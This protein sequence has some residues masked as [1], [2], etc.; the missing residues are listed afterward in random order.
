M[1]PLTWGLTAFVCVALAA[2]VGSAL[3]VAARSGRR[4]AGLKAETPP[5]TLIRPICGLDE[6]ERETLAS[7]FGLEATDVE[8]LFCAKEAN[9]PAALF[10]E[11]LIAAHPA[12]CARLLIGNDLDT[13]NPKLNNVAKGWQAASHG[14]VILADSNLLLPPDYVAQV[15]S[16][17][18]DDTGLVCAPP[19]GARPGNFWAELEC[20]FLNTHAARWQFAVD[21]LGYGFAQGKTMLWRRSDLDS[22]GGI[23]A[24][25]AELAEDAAATKI[26]RACGRRVRLAGPAFEQP[27]GYRTLAQV[28]ARQVRW[29]QLRRLSFP[30]HFAPE[31]LTGLFPPLLAVCIGTLALGQDPTEIAAG[32]TM[33][34]IGSEAFLAWQAG[35]HVS[36]RSP[37]A[38][39]LRDALIP[40]VWA[41]ACLERGYEWRGN[42]IGVDSITART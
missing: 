36:W 40:I 23:A 26:V 11:R 21:S 6:I 34:W 22:Q 15:F 3:I 28:L 30:A 41:R 14:W 18:R 13:E 8:I 7:T 25:A 17:W 27:I 19:I 5:V 33:T 32:L 10:V 42:A 35:W 29:A 39:L 37:F 9:D 24:L 1:E 20:A 38:W 4:S 31:I 12:A 2:H 16:A